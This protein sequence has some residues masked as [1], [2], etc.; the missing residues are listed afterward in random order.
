MD[1]EHREKY[2]S[3]CLSIF[4]LSNICILTYISEYIFVMKLRTV[5]VEHMRYHLVLLSLTLKKTN[6]K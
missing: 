1:L 5:D 3:V 4:H 2:S 6:F